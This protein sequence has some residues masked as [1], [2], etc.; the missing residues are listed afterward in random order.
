[1]SLRSF[2]S[3]PLFIA[4]TTW[5]NSVCLAQVTNPSTGS[6]AADDTPLNT[7]T[8]AVPF[9]S[10][11]GN[12]LQFGTGDVGVVSSNFYSNTAFTSNP[13]LLAN[14]HRYI[15]FKANYT[16]WL[17]SLVPDI[18][19]TTNSIAVGF[20]EHHAIGLYASSFLLGNVQFTDQNG[21]FIRDYNPHE[22]LMQV[23]YATWFDNGLSVGM[24]TKFIYSN[25]TGGLNIG[26][27]ESKPALA[28]AADL[29]L[30]YRG[31]KQLKPSIGLG[32]NIGL[33]FN[34]IG[35][36][37]SYTETN[38]KD[39]L[40][41][42]MQLGIMFS[43]S[44]KFRKTRV[45]C[46]FGYQITKLL[47][48][49]PP[50]YAL[51][52]SGNTIIDYQ[53]NRVITAGKDPNVGVFPGIFQSF[54]DAP[55]GTAEEF[56]EVNHQVMS[57]LRLVMNKRVS[58]HLRNGFHYE[59]VSKGNRQYASVG[60]GASVFGFRF[61]LAYLMPTTA[62]HP[63]SNTIA[64]SVGYR[65]NIGEPQKYATPIWDPLLEGV[66]QKELSEPEDVNAD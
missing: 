9:V 40:P 14:G 6:E 24:G 21:N 16:P 18:H 12:A 13:A 3:I 52:S 46:D 60:L 15:E 35:N 20:S 8:T 7:I 10:L 63:M 57:E 56:R 43:P 29:G 26:G 28:F 66:E 1:M 48:P 17:R 41:M 54:G 4:M 37:V 55:G 47:V 50:E 49:T 27:A 31:K 34:N 22:Y 59:H 19:L 64:I 58:F 61:D 53:G 44:F 51:D 39:F 5:S 33:S 23:N 32:Y 36:K 62:D 25:L 42:N 45:E 11:S 38:E 65:L 2:C 30:H